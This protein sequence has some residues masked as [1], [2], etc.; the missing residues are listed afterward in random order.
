MTSQRNLAAHLPDEGTPAGLLYTIA[1]STQNT[2]RDIEHTSHRLRRKTHKRP[3]ETLT[4]PHCLLLL[5]TAEG[6]ADNSDNC[7]GA[8]HAK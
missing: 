3:P 6:L 1:N 7:A 2:T 5:C 8:A 4:G